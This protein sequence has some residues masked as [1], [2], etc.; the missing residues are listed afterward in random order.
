MHKGTDQG[1]CCINGHKV[2]NGA[3]A[4]MSMETLRQMSY[5]CASILMSSLK[6]NQWFFAVVEYDM[7]LGPNE[8]EMQFNIF[9][10]LFGR[11]RRHSAFS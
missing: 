4:C 9:V 10:H 3:N 6:W 8:W 2:T 11:I 1:F 7:T 5:T